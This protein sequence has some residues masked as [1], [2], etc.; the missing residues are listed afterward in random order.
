[1]TKSQVQKPLMTVIERGDPG[2]L[3]FDPDHY[4]FL[5]LSEVDHWY[6]EQ[7]A[8]A[9]KASGTDR[10]RWRVLMALKW[11]GAANL[12]D[13]AAMT[14][15]KQSTLSRLIERMRADGFVSTALNGEDSRFIDVALAPPGTLELQTLTL[16]A[17][18][19][20]QKALGG[21]PAED[22][23]Q[24]LATLKKITAAIQMN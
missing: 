2:S 1:M 5:A 24:M 21:I 4:L 7:I 14:N 19:V 16:A 17:S 10:S 9:M 22:V 20:Y 8:R 13:L 11:R 6:A 3:N 23:A 12:K 15:I 18:R